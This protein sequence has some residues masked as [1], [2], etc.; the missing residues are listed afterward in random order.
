MFKR[1][2][3]Y[4]LDQDCHL[5]RVEIRTILF[6]IVISRQFCDVI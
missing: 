2:T 5:R 6:S 4:H 1:I 3:Y